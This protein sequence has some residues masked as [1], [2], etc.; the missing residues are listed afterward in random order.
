MKL[1]LAA[2]K[3]RINELAREHGL[4]DFRVSHKTNDRGE[5][6]IALIISPKEPEPGPEKIQG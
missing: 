1:V 4:Q 3:K 5:L 2:L 6:V